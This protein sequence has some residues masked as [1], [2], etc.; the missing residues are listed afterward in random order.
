MI[1]S[2]IS[3]GGTEELAAEEFGPPPAGEQFTQIFQS[4]R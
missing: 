2:L 4:E 3:F 1:F